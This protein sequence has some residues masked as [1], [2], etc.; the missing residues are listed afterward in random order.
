MKLSKLFILILVLN[1]GG[2]AGCSRSGRES[3]KAEKSNQRFDANVVKDDNFTTDT[4]VPVDVATTPAEVSLSGGSLSALYDRKREAVF[5]I[6]STNDGAT[7]SQGS[8]FF[9]SSRGLAVSNKHV[10]ADYRDHY[11][12]LYDGTVFRVSSIVRESDELDYV[13]FRVNTKGLEVSALNIATR[14]PRIGEDVFTIGNPKGLEQTLS[15]GIISS[16][17]ESNKYIQTT[18]EITHG[19][20]G[21]P[22]FNMSGEVVGITT[23]GYGE[24]NLNFA[25]NIQ[26]LDIIAHLE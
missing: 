14:L 1:L 10:F 4:E 23:A 22:L 11:V 24:A 20:S 21:G 7:G 5:L 18:A 6:I 12:K 9:V 8:G 13:I 3:L 2:C 19:S 15:K 17:R 16:Y 26:L 25:V